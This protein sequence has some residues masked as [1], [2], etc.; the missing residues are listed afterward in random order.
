LGTRTRILALAVGLA[1]QGSLAACALTVSVAEFRLVAAPNGSVEASLV[2]L[3][4]EPR[5]VVLSL[6]VTDWD[7]APDGVTHLLPIGD[8]GRSCSRWLDIDTTI[9]SLAA[10]EE[11]VV[12]VVV[13]VPDGAR[14]T[15]WSGLL[16]SAAP[17]GVSSDSGGGIS[18]E[19]LV[20]LFVTIP[21]TDARASVTALSVLSFA[22]LRVHAQLTNLGDVRLSDVTGVL[23]L[24][25][26]SG[27]A[28]SFPLPQINVLPGHSAD[29]DTVLTWQPDADDAGLFLV[30][31]VFDY[32]GE[33]LVAGQI[34]LR[35]P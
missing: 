15:Y 28:I 29:V 25:R 20:R 21:P 23:T 4:D 14:G 11:R 31:A 34:V 19:A 10:F 16:V 9:F 3:N 18:S 32:G 13:R 33:S 30:R 27:P 24:E 35:A 17:T 7:D 6:Q 2:V 1:V 5:G 12:T 8:V 26:S 22:P